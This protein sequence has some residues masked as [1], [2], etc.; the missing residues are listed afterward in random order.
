MSTTFS[1]GDQTRL[2]AVFQEAG[3][4]TD[5]ASVLLRIRD[6]AGAQSSFPYPGSAI[7]RDDVGKYHYDLALITAGVWV[8][9]WEGANQAA[10]EGQIAV[11]Q[12]YIDTGVPSATDPCAQLA[13]ARAQLSSL[14]LGRAVR[15]VE[16]PQLGKVEFQAP[17]FAGLTRLIADLEAQCA[18]AN[19]NF[20]LRRRPISVEVD[21]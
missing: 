4:F 21:P 15:S 16:T 6:G 19:G 12:S 7:V 20:R 5:P 17:S 8:Y 13:L 10:Q 2:T 3:M 11:Q 14:M 18:A 9:R 1:V